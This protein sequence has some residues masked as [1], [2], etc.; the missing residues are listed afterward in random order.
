MH[1]AGL[2]HGLEGGIGVPLGLANPSQRDQP[3][4]R[5][6]EPDQSPAML[7]AFGDVLQ[8]VVELVALVEHLGDPQVRLSRVERGE[9]AALRGQAQALPVGS[10]C[11]SELSSCLLQPRQG[12]S[13]T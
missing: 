3:A 5:F 11:R 1:P 10:Q 7:D 4:T 2:V 6:K 13:R 12:G 8:G 9:P